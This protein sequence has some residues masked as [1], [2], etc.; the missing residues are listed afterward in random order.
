[1]SYTNV[2]KIEIVIFETRRLAFFKV[3]IGIDRIMLL[4]PIFSDNFSIHFIFWLEEKQQ[5]MGIILRQMSETN[6]KYDTFNLFNFSV[7]FKIHAK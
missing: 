7:S 5:N 2:R 3:A 1:M 4:L 6:R